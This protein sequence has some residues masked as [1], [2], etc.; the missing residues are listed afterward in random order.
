MSDFSLLRFAIETSRGICCAV[1]DVKS[2]WR[3]TCR[4]GAAVAKLKLVCRGTA[5]QVS[6]LE[7]NVVLTGSDGHVRGP[8]ESAPLGQGSLLT[9]SYDSKV[10]FCVVVQE[11]IRLS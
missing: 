9:V 10:G 6:K 1:D 8:K 5:L 7:G 4:C 11:K 3:L 2:M